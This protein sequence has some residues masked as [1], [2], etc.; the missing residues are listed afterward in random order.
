MV[1]AKM[2]NLIG[3]NIKSVT[4][5]YDKNYPDMTYKIFEIMTANYLKKNFDAEIKFPEQTKHRIP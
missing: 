2:P 1:E 3:K 4:F 5:T